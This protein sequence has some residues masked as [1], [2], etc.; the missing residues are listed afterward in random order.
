MT[1]WWVFHFSMLLRDALQDL[2][3][4]LAIF[5]KKLSERKSPNIGLLRYRIPLASFGH[6]RFSGL[7]LIIINIIPRPIHSVA[8]AWLSSV[9]EYLY[10]FLS[11]SGSLSILNMPELLCN[12]ILRLETTCFLRNEQ[13]SDIAGSYISLIVS[14]NIYTK[15]YF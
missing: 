1:I 15:F 8:L 5:R 13:W 4:I 11:L 3:L 10:S 6:W 9:L 12:K 7:E 2:Q 14:A